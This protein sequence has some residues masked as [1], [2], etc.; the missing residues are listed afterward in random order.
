MDRDDTY[1]SAYNHNDNFDDM[2]NIIDAKMNAQIEKF[3]ALIKNRKRSSSSSRRRSSAQASELPSPARSHRH[4]HQHSHEEIMTPASRRPMMNKREFHE[5]DTNHYSMTSP[6]T[7][8]SLHFHMRHLHRQ[9][10]QKK[11]PKIKSASS[12]SYYDFDTKYKTPFYGTHDPEEY[13]EWE[14][15]MDTYLKLLQVPPKDQVK[16]ATRNFHDYAS[17]WWLHTSLKSFDKSWSKTNKALWREFVP[18]TYI[19]HL[20]R[21]LET[22]IQGSKSIDEYFMKMKKSLRRS[23]MATPFG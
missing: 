8:A 16:C 6:T 11:L 22:T 12:T 19:E 15:K 14:R 23:G 3:K 9:A 13:L 17:T 1:T 21:H 2:K 18:P 4:W 5:I 20:Q 7:L 10:P